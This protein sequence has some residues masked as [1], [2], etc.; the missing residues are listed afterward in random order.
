MRRAVILRK[1]LDDTNPTLAFVFDANSEEQVASE[2]DR[3]MAADIAIIAEDSDMAGDELREVYEEWYG[4]EW[5]WEHPR[6][7]CQC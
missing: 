7:R 4:W 5:V 6:Y 3:L 1:S 2:M